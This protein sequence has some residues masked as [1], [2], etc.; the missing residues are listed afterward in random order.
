MTAI[1]KNI[2]NGDIACEASIVISDNKDAAG[3][4]KAKKFGILTKTVECTDRKQFDAD[5]I[6]LLNLYKVDYVILA[7][8]MRILS[9]KFVSDFENRILN[10]H[11]ALL[12]SF[13]GLNAQ[14]QALDAGVR[15]AGCTVHFVTDDLDGGPII[16]QAAVPVKSNDTVETLSERILK[17]EHRIYSAAIALL[18]KNKLEIKSGR[19]IIKDENI[20][21]NQF[22][23]VP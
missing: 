5:V 15:I 3:L 4:Q 14:K 9:H 21:T 19:V 6:G 12:P 22:M 10:I 23:I 18:V 8:F 2:E 13:Q 20:D 7:G 17:K 11:P 16:M 1:L